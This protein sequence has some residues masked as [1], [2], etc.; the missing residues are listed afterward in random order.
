MEKRKRYL[1]GQ[2]IE[3]REELQALQSHNVTLHTIAE[4]YIRASSNVNYW[5]VQYAVFLG[6]MLNMFLRFVI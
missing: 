5:R 3:I 6:H 4:D 2:V 1:T